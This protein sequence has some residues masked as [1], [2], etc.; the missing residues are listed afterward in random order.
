ALVVFGFLALFFALNVNS[1]TWGA[2]NRFA[3]GSAVAALAL[4]GAL[5][6][7]DGVGLKQAIDAWVSAPASEQSAFFAVVRG[8]RG[9]EGGLRSYVDFTTGLTLALFATVIVWTA[10]LLGLSGYIL[11]FIMG[12]SGLTYI[13]QGYGYGT[14]YTAIS[15]SPFLLPSTDYQFLNI[16]WSIW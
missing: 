6:A 7:V 3:A 16:V 5:Y 15:N 9:V 1:G 10:R 4:N 13:L 2:V 12:L 11:G 8:V 14:D